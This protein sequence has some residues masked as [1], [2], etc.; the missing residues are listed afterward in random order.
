[1]NNKSIGNV[2]I[3]KVKS[4][5]YIPAKE[6]KENRQERKSN[7]KKVI[8]FILSISDQVNFL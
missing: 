1:M 7:V 4:D 3:L 6:F 2:K 8:Y 5:E